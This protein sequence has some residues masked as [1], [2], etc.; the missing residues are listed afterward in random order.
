LTCLLLIREHIIESLTIGTSH[1]AMTSYAQ[2]LTPDRPLGTSSEPTARACVRTH[3][4]QALSH[5][6]FG[7]CNYRVPWTTGPT[8]NSAGTL[9]EKLPSSWER[10]LLS[11]GWSCVPASL[12]LL[13]WHGLGCACACAC[14]AHSSKRLCIS[15][16]FVLPQ[17]R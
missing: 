5:S 13:V 12:L 3:L 2:L 10:C 11:R 15:P 17:F 4:G 8:P 6:S 1:R 7:N 16:L 9:L 14:G